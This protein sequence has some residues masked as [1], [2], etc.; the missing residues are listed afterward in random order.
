MD[1]YDNLI[2]KTK[3]SY[4]YFERFCTKAKYYLLIDDDVSFNPSKIMKKLDEQDSQNVIFGKRWNRAKGEQ[5]LKAN[6]NL[7]KAHDH[8]WLIEKGIKI[9]QDQWEKQFWPDYIAGP[10]AFMTAESARDMAKTATN[11]KKALTIPIEGTTLIKIN[12]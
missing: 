9:S 11:T 3:T 10:C 5:F 7:S 12:L 4:E 1:T 6:L 2:L 8:P